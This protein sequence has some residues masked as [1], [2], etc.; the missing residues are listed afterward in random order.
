[1]ELI[2]DY[3]TAHGK[4]LLFLTIAFVTITSKTDTCFYGM[5]Y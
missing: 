4:D 3:F 5:V 2:L 1:L